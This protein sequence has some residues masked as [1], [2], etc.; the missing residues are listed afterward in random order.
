MHIKT[1]ITKENDYISEKEW[2]YQMQR[3][4]MNHYENARYGSNPTNTIGG[5]S[6]LLSMIKEVESAIELMQQDLF[7]DN[8]ISE[9]IRSAIVLVSSDT[10]ALIGLKEILDKTYRQ[11][12]VTGGCSYKTLAIT[13]SNLIETEANYRHWLK[14]SK[15][16]SKKYAEDNNLDFIPK[17]IA[18]RITIER[19]VTQR[20][21][22][23]WQKKF[24]DLTCYKWTEEQKLYVGDFVL[25]AIV[26]ALPKYFIVDVKKSRTRQ[27]KQIIMQSELRNKIDNAEITISKQQVIR[28]PMLV[29]PVPWHIEEKKLPQNRENEGV[30]I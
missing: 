16:D 18:Q 17:S 20:Q 26:N 2:E 7:D 11:N 12:L 25:S 6:L 30:A 22:K 29:K 1:L 14:V 4:G 24:E 28:K 8:T 23:N 27:T 15:E 5:Q 21:I 19:G 9:S 3:A 10:L 13:I